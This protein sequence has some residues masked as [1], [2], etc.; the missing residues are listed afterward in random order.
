M[1]A[2][3]GRRGGLLLEASGLS[4]CIF[5]PVFHLQP[6]FFSLAT[7]SLMK[8]VT[9]WETYSHFMLA[10]QRHISYLQSTDSFCS[11]SA[12]PREVY[13][14]RLLNQL[15]ERRQLKL[16]MPSLPNVLSA[17]TANRL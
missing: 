12:G 13:S 9:L 10:S 8:V 11:T 6:H 5:T 7:F 2:G 14:H 15:R 16:Q 3:G 4:V 17:A 1:E